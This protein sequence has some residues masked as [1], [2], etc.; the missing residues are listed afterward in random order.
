MAEKQIIQ[1]EGWA[2]PKGYANGVVGEG[3][4]LFV[5]GMVGWDPS[6]ETAKFPKTFAEQFDQ[7]LS[8]V[9]EVV[10]AAGGKPTD[11]AR[12]TVY[13]TDKK[14]YQASLKDIGASW[15]A[16]LGRH[17]PAMALIVVSALLEDEAMVE[18]EA[19][20]VL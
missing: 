8:N 13:V 10:T 11:L 7:A 14:A 4:V 19:T 16:R 2:K 3:R 5:G 20:A 18:I 1:P 6:S 17:Y 9:L 15:R 12:M